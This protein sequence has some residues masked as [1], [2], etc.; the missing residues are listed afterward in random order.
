MDSSIGCTSG[1]QRS[2]SQLSEVRKFG[3]ALGESRVDG[4]L[5]ASIMRISAVHCAGVRKSG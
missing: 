5:F 2:M 1:D 4:R 3:S